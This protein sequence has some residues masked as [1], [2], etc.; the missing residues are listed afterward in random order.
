MKPL[1]RVGIIGDPHGEAELLRAALE[2]LRALQ[3][4]ALLCT[5]DAIDGGSDV[6][7]CVALLQEFSVQTVRGNHDRWLFQ[8]PE[9]ERLTLPLAAPR[10]SVS[11]QTRDFLLAL[12]PTREFAT[13]AGPLLLCHGLGDNDMAKLTPDDYGYALEANVELQTLLR[14]SY[15]FAVGG[16]THTRMVRHFTNLNT[17]GDFTFIN[18]GTL[19]STHP[20]KIPCCTCADFAAQTVTFYNLLPTL[21]EAGT[22]AL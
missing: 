22:F 1:Q 7:A 16:H 20:F 9:P 15:R 19:L 2:L 21:H 10:E 5:G 3:P 12:P 4:D 14:A 17:G 11:L 8:M 13:V 6:N 18:A